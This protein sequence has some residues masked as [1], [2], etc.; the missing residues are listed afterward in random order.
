MNHLLLWKLFVVDLTSPQFVF[1]LRTLQ[2][3]LSSLYERILANTYGK[4]CLA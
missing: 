1:H 4:D 2:S 3:P